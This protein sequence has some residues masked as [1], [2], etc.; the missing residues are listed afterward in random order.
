MF[1]YKT[2]CKLPPSA[3]EQYSKP[4]PITV[5]WWKYQPVIHT[6]NECTSLADAPLF[7]LVRLEQHRR[8]H[9]ERNRGR[10]GCVLFYVM[11]LARFATSRSPV[12]MLKTADSE[13]NFIASSVIS[14]LRVRCTAAAVEAAAAYAS[15]AFHSDG[16]I[17]KN[18]ETKNSHRAKSRENRAARAATTTLVSCRKSCGQFAVLRLM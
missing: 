6:L 2:A 5:R 4:K 12:R 13:R 18:S 8:R 16:I 3:V 11:T 17:G 1:V 9:C 14:S 10:R 7:D 15:C